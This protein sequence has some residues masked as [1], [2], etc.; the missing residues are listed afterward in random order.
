MSWAKRIHSMKNLYTIIGLKR[1]CFR[2]ALLAVVF[3]VL[4]TAVLADSVVVFNE[5]MYH[6]PAGAA[7]VEWVELHNQLAIDV[8]ISRWSIKGGVKYKF[9]DGTFIPAGGYIVVANDPTALETETG[10]AGAFGPFEGS[11]SNS[12]EQL[13]LVNNGRRVMDGVDYKDS[14][15]W[16]VAPDGSGV[17]LTK[18][19]PDTSSQLPENW[20]W[21]Q[22]VNG[23]PGEMNFLLFDY[24]SP[25][26]TIFS[27][28]LDS[29]GN[30]LAPG[31]QD[32]HYTFVAGGNPAITMDDNP[33][34]LQV[35]KAINFGDT[36]DQT[37]SGVNFLTARFNT[38]VDGVTNTAGADVPAGWSGA[39]TPVI[40]I[41]ADD[42]ALEQIFATSIYGGNYDIDIT[43]PNGTYK[44]Q[45]LLY[46]AWY[47]TTPRADFTVEGTLIAN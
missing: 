3:L 28:G 38:T 4:T 42:N 17:S 43:V 26:T 19:D 44:L 14:G 45:F 37:V 39:S 33:D 40:G 13:R 29:S 16:P 1:T 30:P 2:S 6:P 9:Q 7:D 22:Q 47:Q 36:T 15:D 35:V 32:P 18:R 25:L 34:L 24:I 46:E 21:S 27:S 31:Q 5:I 23:T 8:D 10:Y 41:T 12:G 20:T 11:L